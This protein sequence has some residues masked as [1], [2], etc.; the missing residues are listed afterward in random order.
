MSNPATYALSA[1][2]FQ[3]MA[4]GFR[5]PPVSSP[6]P[7][8]SCGL[9]PGKLTTSLLTISETKAKLAHP[10]RA[11]SRR[12][13]TLPEFPMS[14]TSTLPSPAIADAQFFDALKR[15]WGYDAFR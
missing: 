12:V 14:D 11:P 8:L 2:K 6:Q 9:P 3:L 4:Y 1:A 15:Y 13:A 10:L 7:F 5:L